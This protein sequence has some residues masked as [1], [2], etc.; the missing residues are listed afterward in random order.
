MARPGKRSKSHRH[1]CDR[2]GVG[3]IALNPGLTMVLCLLHLVPGEHVT[4]F[5][6]RY[7]GEQYELRVIRTTC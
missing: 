3:L 2:L 5:I 7:P 4:G 6:P 1:T